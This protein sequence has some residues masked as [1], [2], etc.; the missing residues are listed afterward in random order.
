MLP[1]NVQKILMGYSFDDDYF[2]YL[3]YTISQSD[4]TT[5]QSSVLI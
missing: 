4:A 2:R 5:H 1:K 3:L